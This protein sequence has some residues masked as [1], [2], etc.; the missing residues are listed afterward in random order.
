MADKL[1]YG[2]VYLRRALQLVPRRRLATRPILQSQY[3]S[4][5][6]AQHMFDST[7]AKP[8]KT[9]PT[10]EAI[11][12]A[13][14]KAYAPKNSNR[15]TPRS[16]EDGVENSVSAEKETLRVERVAKQELKYLADDPWK[17][18]QY[19]KQ[20]LEK[21][22]FE[23][24][25]CVVKMGSR[26]LSLVVPWTMLMDYMLQQQ[27]LTK[28]IRIFNDM[29]KRAQFPNAQ[30]YTTLFRGLARSQH[31]KLAVAEA[32]KQ[33]NNLLKDSR[34]EPNTTHLNAVL[35]VCNR[36]GD[37]DSMFSIVDTI[38]DT[39]R[40]ATAYTY[41][42]IISALRWNANSDIKDLTDD[43]KR[44]NIRNSVERAKVIWGEAM[45]KWRQGRLVIDEEFVCTMCRLMI[46]SSEID[47][48]KEI[49][50]IVE[51]TMNVPNLSK[52]QERSAV[53]ARKTDPKTGAVA[54]KDGN[55]VYASPGNNTLS[56]LLNV[57]HQTK[58]SSIG[59]KYWNFLVREHNI[60]PDRDCWMRLFSILKQARA[61]A[62][63]TEIL[64]IVPEDT[65]DPRIYRMAMETCI[66]DNINQNVIKNADRALDN[67]MERTE[68]PDPQTMRL[69]LTA[70]QNTHYHLRA[71]A[72]DGDVAGAK[73]AY[74]IQVTKAL[75]RL[76]VPYRKLHD[77]FF[78]DAKAKTDL[79][80]GILYNQQREVIALA[81][82]MYGSFNKVI[83]QEML[84]EE[85]LQRIRPIG[86][87][88][89]REIQTFFAKRQEKEPN[90]RKTKGRGAAEEE[91]SEYYT[92]MEIES[93]WDTT[94]A[95][96]PQRDRRYEDRRSR[97]YD[98]ERRRQNE[99]RRGIDSNRPN[100]AG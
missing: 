10:A 90:L 39:T 77:H 73:R 93:F 47:D 54:K 99:G 15:D 74:G 20:A 29:K 79:D 78:R 66:R 42:T 59:I 14:T 6:K 91:M 27:Q 61:S 1:I 43:Q 68:T 64:S 50:D 40:A 5:H 60:E 3:R 11:T 36:A 24:A 34:L 13:I 49:L 38:N 92:V 63:A 84:P 2:G 86:G 96:R 18:S 70:V 58:Q 48:K 100:L 23:E 80:E 22:K 30:T 33:Y 88:I 56:L 45:S 72:N 41:A 46:L 31:P 81:R 55:G 21:G 37:L 28:A 7:T 94:Q 62:H 95:G 25:Y 52:V 75:D 8:A 76:W 69:Y 98:N 26:T 83:Q 4:F 97:G 82:I 85:D 71:R 12:A 89:N 19:V 9:T 32:V 65:I 16:L 87:R 57:V 35:N 44:F 53:D 51:Q 17:F 67:M